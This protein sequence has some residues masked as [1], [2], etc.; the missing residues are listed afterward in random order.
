MPVSVVRS[1]TR[2][3]FGSRLGVPSGSGESDSRI[4]FGGS[5][6]PGLDDIIDAMS[7]PRCHVITDPECP[8]HGLDVTGGIQSHDLTEQL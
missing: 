4:L 7:L 6:V 2:A 3:L 5:R 1:V 8:I